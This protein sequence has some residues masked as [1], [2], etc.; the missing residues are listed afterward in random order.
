MTSDGD[1]FPSVFE[2]TDTEKIGLIGLLQN[3]SFA[4]FWG[5]FVGFR[6]ADALFLMS[7]FWWVLDVTG[8]ESMLS[9]VGI[10]NYLP[11]FLLG[12]VAGLL[13]DMF[14]RKRILLLSA[15]SRAILMILIPLLNHFFI[16]EMWHIYVIVF[17]LGS[18][19]TLFLNSASA[20]IPQ[21]AREEQ[22]MAANSLVDVGSWS[23][24]ILGYLIGGLMIESFGVMSTLLLATFSMVFASFSLIFL[25]ARSR[26]D[27]EDVSS[28]AALQNLKEGI[29]SIKQD[30]GVAI[31]IGTW[32]G[33]QIL[34]GAGPMSI[35]L[36]VFAREVLGT[37][38][39]GYGFITVAIAIGSLLLSI[40]LGQKSPK[41]NRAKL[42]MLG[43]LW[44]SFGMFIFSLTN[45]LVTAIIV[46]FLWNLCYPLI[47]ISFMSVIHQRVPEKRLGTVFGFGGTLAQGMTPISIAIT[48]FIMENIS[49]VLPFQLF[50]GALGLC[51]FLMLVSSEI[52][53]L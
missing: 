42:M 27:D 10:F 51:F 41:S 13:T 18:A 53:R 34:F 7:V 23:A 40:A 17:L 32:Y 26:R 12:L 39:E 3:R 6:V 30:H 1:L 35:G 49:I 47:N 48:G 2:P 36:P 20:I 14:D 25:R 16:I 44:G 46:A 37:G 52:R 38:A 45:T 28:R 31:L 8:S 9:I 5:G 4:A 15:V 43:Y 50:A 21:L 29:E 19:F 33:F 24:N 11:G 22:L